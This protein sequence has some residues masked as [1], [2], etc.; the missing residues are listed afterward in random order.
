M[1]GLDSITDSVDMNLSK[2][3]E[4]VKDREACCT[5]MELQSWT[6]LSNWKT[7]PVFKSAFNST[8]DIQYLFSQNIFFLYFTTMEY[9]LFSSSHF[10]GRDRSNGDEDTQEFSSHSIL[11]NVNIEIGTD[12]L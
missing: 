9:F 8:Y 12:F 2:L 1:R 11:K 4:M 10:E 3:Q 5:S 6:W 7:P